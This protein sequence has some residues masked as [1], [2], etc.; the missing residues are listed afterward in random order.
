MS[1]KPSQ[2]GSYLQ[3]FIA[4]IKQASASNLLNEIE[5]RKLRDS[6]VMKPEAAKALNKQMDDEVNNLRKLDT[7]I[8]AMDHYCAVLPIVIADIVKHEAEDPPIYFALKNLVL[9]SISSVL[10]LFDY[11]YKMH[12]RIANFE[13]NDSVRD[14]FASY[15]LIDYVKIVQIA[16]WFVPIKPIYKEPTC[17]IYQLLE[18]LF[19]A[20]ESDSFYTTLESRSQ[21]LANYWKSQAE[22]DLINQGRAIPG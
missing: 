11:Y 2:H 4:K 17:K 1:S 7:L 9:G 12:Y 19:K 14:R 15:R 8:P 16:G 21:K 3:D 22:R 13:R 6:T 10:G 5:D 18:P 20:C